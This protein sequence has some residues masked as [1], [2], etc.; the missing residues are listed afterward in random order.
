MAGFVPACAPAFDAVVCAVAEA[1]AADVS[2]EA[3]VVVVEL[4]AA[5]GVVEGIELVAFVGETGAVEEG[6]V[7]EAPLTEFL[8]EPGALPVETAAAVA[9]AAA[10]VEDDPSPVPPVKAGEEA[11]AWPGLVIGA[12]MLV[13]R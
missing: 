6:P 9:G 7:E 5:A 12:E 11:P 1:V 13:E 2:V 3:G 8:C 4:A 10:A